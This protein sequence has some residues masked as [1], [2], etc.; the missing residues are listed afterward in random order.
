MYQSKALT[1][2]FG[3]GS[4]RSGDFGIHLDHQVFL[5]DAQL[6][7]DLNLLLDP[8]RELVTDDRVAD[9]ANPFLQNPEDFLL[10][11]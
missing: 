5:L 9:V 6:V 7:P 1:A 3:G 4:I 8:S 10:C 11:R 2:D